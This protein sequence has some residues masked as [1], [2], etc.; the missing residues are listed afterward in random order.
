MNF[1]KL[2]NTRSNPTIKFAPFGRWDALSARPLA[3][4]Q[5][6]SP[7]SSFRAEALSILGSVVGVA[8]GFFLAQVRRDDESS[9]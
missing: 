1:L 2:S 9:V 8:A 3:L 6:P 5:G 4:L 7:Q